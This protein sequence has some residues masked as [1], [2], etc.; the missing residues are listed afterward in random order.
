MTLSESFESLATKHDLRDLEA[1]FQA[2][3]RELEARL[4]ADIEKMRVD[5]GKM[6]D[7]LTIRMAAMLM[8]TGGLVI[9]VIKYVL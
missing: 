8:A 3:L 9:A 7:D 5:M 1:I 6:K 4:R 2:D